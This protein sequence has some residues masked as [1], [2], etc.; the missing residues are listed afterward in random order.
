LEG[1]PLAAAGRDLVPTMPTDVDEAA[2][3]ARPVASDDDRDV[4]RAARH[5]CPRL[6]DRLD[7][8]RVLPAAAED[9][10]LLQPVDL[11]VGVPRRRQ[12]QAAVELLAEI[13]LD[14]DGHASALHV[15]PATATR[16]PKRRATI[17]PS[18]S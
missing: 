12:R 4:A 10:L 14:D 3:H 13:G 17:E 11:G 2:E 8:P 5:E 16:R 15:E 9:T 6:R 7:R 18:P 1:L